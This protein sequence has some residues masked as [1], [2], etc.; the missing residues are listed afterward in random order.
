MLKETLGVIGIR[1]TTSHS[2]KALTLS[3]AFTK[4]LSSQ[5][6]AALGYH[7]IDGESKATKAYTRDRLT[8]PVHLLSTM[9]SEVRSGAFDPDRKA[10]D[11]ADS[12][13]EVEKSATQAWQNF[14]EVIVSPTAYFVPQE[15]AEAHEEK[16]KTEAE[17]EET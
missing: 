17:N 8:R 12:V 1:Q 14:G 7:K 4:G 15:E 16:Q 13:E 3:W 11:T 5:D 10:C 6:R 2:M 9:L